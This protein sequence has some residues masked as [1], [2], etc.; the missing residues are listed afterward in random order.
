MAGIV[1]IYCAD[2]RPADAGELQRMA[3]ALS[4]RAPDGTSYWN[5]GPIG[6]AHLQFCTTP[7][8]LREH[9]PLFAPWAEACLVFDGRLDNREDLSQ[10]IVSSGGRFVDDT[11]PGLVLSAYLVW[12]EECAER[13]VGDFAFVIWDGRRRRLWC[14]RDYLGVRHFYYF[15]DGS[16]FLFASEIPALLTHPRVSLKINEGMVGEYLADKITSREDTLYSDIHRLTPA[17][18]LTISGPSNDLRIERY[19]KPDLSPITYQT[20]DQY[21]EH[22]IEILE[23]SIASRMR[24]CVPWATELSGGLDSSTV[25]VTAQGLLNRS[26]SGQRVSTFSLA[27]PGMPWDESQYINE[28]TQFAGLRSQSFPA[29]YPDLDYFQ[30]SAACSRDFP[31]YPNGKAMFTK[32]HEAMRQNGVRVLISGQGG[33]QLLEGNPPHLLDLAQACDFR[34]LVQRAKDDWRIYSGINWQTFLFRRLASGWAPDWIRSG[35]RKRRLSRSGILSRDFM[36]RIR[37]GDRLYSLNRRDPLVFSSRAQEAV[38]SSAH[39][40]AA[41][42]YAEIMDRD[43][44]LQ[45]FEFRHPFFD[46]RLAVFCLR[47]PE[48]QRQR[49]TTWKWVLRNATRGKLPERVRTKTIQAHFSDMYTNLFTTRSTRDRLSNLLIRKHTDWLNP[50]LGAGHP[51]ALPDDHASLSTSWMALGVDMWLDDLMGHKKL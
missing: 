32:M 25:S 11:D 6:F 17:C 4:H 44:A 49:G 19:W 14:A 33:N 28:I 46:R 24:S 5:S 21:A 39:G 3:G 40:G 10:A 7:E 16:T 42:H 31:G 45:G 43:A 34:R 38:F 50:H 23:Q 47:M 13:L 51:E 30:R 48:D 18:S 20:D 35:L 12:G 8:S 15:W 36:K 27:Q 9:Q 22:F 29:D 37:L 41:T 26:G 2:G 1:G